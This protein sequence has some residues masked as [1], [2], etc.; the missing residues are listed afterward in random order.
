MSR[1]MTKSTKL[2]WSESSLCDQWVAKDPRFLHVDSKD[3]DQTG[4][5]SRLIWVFAGRTLIWLVLSCRGSN[6]HET[7]AF[8][9]TPTNI[10]MYRLPTWISGCSLSMAPWG[11]ENMY[12][13][14]PFLVS[15]NR[16]KGPSKQCRSRSDATKRGL[17][18]VLWSG[19]TASA[20]YETKY[21]IEL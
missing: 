17:C 4:R 5:M 3:S 7:A 16:L 21:S 14:N 1:D 6:A 13:L 20:Y 18:R 2:V 10:S 11:K 12:L 9:C 15:A 19:P 8:L